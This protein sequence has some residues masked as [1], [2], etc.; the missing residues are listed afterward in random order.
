MLAT[1]LAMMCISDRTEV[2]WPEILL[3][4]APF[5]I[6][7]GWLTAATILNATY[8]LKSFGMHDKDFNSKGLSHMD[9]G[10][11]MTLGLS[12]QVWTAIILSVALIIY[13]LASWIERNPLYG[14]VFLW[15]LGG[16]IADSSENNRSTVVAAAGS[17]AIVHTISLLTL[18]GYLLYEEF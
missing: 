1:S 13:T 17:I 18:T 7:S 3:V 16:I 6:Y 8:M 11:W 9:W 14:A 15:A 2:W 12:E 4:R 5:S 10:S